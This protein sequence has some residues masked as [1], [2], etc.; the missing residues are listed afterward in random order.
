MLSYLYSPLFYGVAAAF[1]LLGG[2][3]FSVSLVVTQT[4]TLSWYFGDAAI[5]LLFIAPLLTM[6][7]FAEE[8]ARGTDELL[9]TLPLPTWRVV[10]GKYLAALAV[11]GLLLAG[12]IAYLFILAAV[13]EP[14]WGEVASSY[15]GM[16]LLLAAFLAVGCLASALTASPLLA[17]VGG[18]ALLLLLWLAGWAADVLQGAPGEWM[19]SLAMSARFEDFLRGVVDSSHVVFF[20]SIALAALVLTTMVLERGTVR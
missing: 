11:G 9:F 13:G 14:R 5:L 4:A 8:R 2:Y 18:F 16:V 15:L 1:L 7:L 12:S 19:R 6:R 3:F 20:L 17:A 10:L